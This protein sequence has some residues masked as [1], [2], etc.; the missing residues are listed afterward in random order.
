[1][2]TAII[3]FLLI[4]VVLIILPVSADQVSPIAAF[5]SNM[6]SGVV[7]LAVQFVD[8]SSNSPAAWTWTFGDGGSSTLQNPSHLYTTPGTYTVILTATNSAGSN[9]DS[10]TNYIMVN[11]ASPP[12]ASFTS[13]IS[14]GTVPLAVNFTDT[15]TNSPT[16]WAWS[17]GDGGWST[18]ENPSYIY[19]TPG[20]YTVSLTA[21]NYGGSNAVTKTNY[22]TANKAPPPVASFTSNVTGG[23]APLNVG[24]TDTSTNSPIAWAWTFGD[25]GTST[26][27]NPVHMYTTAGTYTVSLLVTNYGGSNS[28][29]ETNYITVSGQSLPAASFI[30]SSTAGPVPLVVNFTDTSTNSPIAW[31][32][33]FGD[34]GTST[35]QNPSYIY[36]TP[37]TY[38]VSLTV[39]N[40]G[41]NGTLTQ[42]NYIRV[43]PPSPVASF[44]SDVTSGSA[45]LMVDFTDTST[46][47][48]IAW[49]WTFGDGGT[50]TAQN[51]SYTYTA[52]GTYTVSLLATNTAGSNSITKSNY[53]TVSA[54]K[55]AQVTTYTTIPVTSTSQVAAT[56][57]PTMTGGQNTS[58]PAGTESSWTFPVLVIA[59][60]FFFCAVILLRVGRKP[61]RQG[62]HRGGDL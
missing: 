62:R 44:I 26:V 59:I 58:G 37:G 47:S 32:W 35:V 10:A 3:W 16:V 19:T 45:P 60:I 57:A 52:P 54:A 22:I 18:L 23:S 5:T 14:V 33:T 24:F 1:M 29:T 55:A 34:G 20:T 7:P 49:A 36:T 46:N 11:K 61:Q 28:V 8:A 31:A 21:T 41:G 43:V 12:V 56:A 15:S 53:I 39:T 6:T 51:P 4:A 38:T 40:Y 2:K 30:A 9:T 48:P 50:S 27:Q 42:S 13:N 17:F 25:G